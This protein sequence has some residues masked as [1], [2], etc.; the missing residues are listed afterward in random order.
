MRTE[1]FSSKADA[2]RW[3]NENERDLITRYRARQ[4]WEAGAPCLKPEWAPL[5]RLWNADRAVTESG[6]EDPDE[7]VRIWLEVY[8]ACR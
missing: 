7:A 5:Y 1:G 6:T 2:V 8:D 4:A 3:C